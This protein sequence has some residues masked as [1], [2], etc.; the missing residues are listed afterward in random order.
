[1]AD[2]HLTYVLHGSANRFRSGRQSNHYGAEK[3]AP[4]SVNIGPVTIRLVYQIDFFL[5]FVFKFPLNV[6][7]VSKM[8]LLEMNKKYFD[9]S[10]LY[11]VLCCEKNDSS[12]KSE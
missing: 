11:M 4:K 2:R 10:N 1:M 12:Q 3:L 6:I 8:D 5:F 7:I 9:T